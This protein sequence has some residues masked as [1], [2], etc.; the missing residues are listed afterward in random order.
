MSET[1]TQSEISAEIADIVPA[2]LLAKFAHLSF[3]EMAEKR[4]CE[5]F[6]AELLAAERAWFRAVD[7]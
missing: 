6:R 2:N 7:A 4:E 1:R 5:E 3:G